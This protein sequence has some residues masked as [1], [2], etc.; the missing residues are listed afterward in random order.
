[1]IPQTPA[2]AR[3]PVGADIQNSPPVGDRPVGQLAPRDRRRSARSAAPDAMT[4][5]RTVTPRRSRA[6]T[7]ACAAPA[8]RSSRLRASCAVQ[9]VQRS[10]RCPHRLRSPG[11]DR[12]PVACE[13]GRVDRRPAQGS[14]AIDQQVDAVGLPEVSPANRRA[15]VHHVS[16]GRIG[17]AVEQEA[18]RR[19]DCERVKRP[20][21]V[22]TRRNTVAFMSRPGTMASMSAPCARR[23]SA[24]SSPL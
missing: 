10:P 8:D 5:A 16:D 19:L 24:T 11:L 17:P 7:S 3:K 9:T 14:G 13:A 18:E 4:L 2:W 20:S 1:M 15:V 6:F 23:K 12:A 21:A 22:A